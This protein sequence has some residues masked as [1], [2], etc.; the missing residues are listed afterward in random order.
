MPN[1]HFVIE[2]VSE[3]AD[4]IG[5]NNS[6]FSPY[7]SG[8]GRYVAY[9][10]FA[11]NF[12]PDDGNN[13]ND[14]FVQDRK[15]GTTEIISVDEDGNEGNSGS[16]GPAI[17][18]NGRFV[19]YYSRASNLVPNDAN[20]NEPDIFIHDRK[21][22]TTEIISLAGDGS[23]GNG[24]S[25]S[26]DIS[27]GG[28][29][30]VYESDSSNLVPGDGN[31]TF[32]VFLY[33]RKKGSTERISVS[34]L[35]DEATGDS[36]QASLSSDGRYVTYTSFASDLVSG[37]SNDT[38]DVFVFDRKRGT[39]ELVPVS[40]DGGAGNDASIS[41][42]ISANGR[43]VT[44]YSYASNLVPGDNNSLLDVFVHDRKLGTT[45]RVSVAS[46]GAEGNGESYQA[47]ISDDGRFVTFLSN[48]TN[49]VPSDNNGTWDVFI[50]DR[51]KD[52][53]TLL[54]QGIDG[55]SGNGDSDDPSISANG[56]H[57]VFTS[58]APDLVLG[59]DNALPDVFVA[60][61]FEWL[62]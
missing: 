57:V 55:T 46:N 36:F 25:F 42:A 44:F 39:T 31:G 4:G 32:D 15:L 14:I 60:S 17:S 50:H 22:D 49:L 19:A 62:V 5:G 29:Y 23:A 16:D 28:R 8:D 30:V 2:R 27:A 58:A 47:S 18:D 61:R 9:S 37:D 7:I 51:R 6:S 24:A 26:P 35:G 48:A 40:S 12:A 13:T 45:E 11:S 54:S 1:K 34:S 59:D 56:K 33:D 53:T 3:I 21:T 38:A 43:F 41:S 20:G 52:T 10:S